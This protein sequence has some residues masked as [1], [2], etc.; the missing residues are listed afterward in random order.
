MPVIPSG[1]SIFF[2]IYNEVETLQKLTI[3]FLEI[4]RELSPDP[5]VLIID[6]GSTDGSSEMAD[7]LTEK[8]SILKVIHHNYNLGYGA[9]LKSGFTN[10][11]KDLIFYTDGD[12]Q[13]DICELKNVLPL[14]ENADV[15]SCYRT[16]RQDPWHRRIN[17]LLYKIAVRLIFDLNFKDPDCAFKIY[18]KIV[19]D[20]ISMKSGGA[21]IDVEM[22]LQAKRH[23][24][25]IVQAGVTHYPRRFGKSSGAN[26]R[27]I[28]KAI[29]EIILLGERLGSRF[30]P[31]SP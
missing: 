5:E 24:F 21:C 20:S 27:V 29:S 9:A 7:A 18:R 2:P 16:N 19:V 14:I 15:V 28:M 4:A 17:A 25:R 22:L 26:L 1:L 31:K 3:Q 11:S 6:D 23:G 10:A 12:G 8:N 30:N 13:F